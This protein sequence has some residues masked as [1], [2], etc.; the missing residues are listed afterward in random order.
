MRPG[1][2]LA[3]LA[4][5]ASLAAGCGGADEAP[6]PDA[7]WTSFGGDPANTRWSPLA[8]VDTRS[9]GRLGVA[10]THD[11]PAGGLWETFPLVDGR[12]MYLTSTGGDVLALDATTG[13]RRWTFQPQTDFLAAGGG[14]EVQPVSRGVALGDGRVYVLTYDE[15][16]IALDAETGAERWT[17]RVADTA[18]GYT[19]TSPP[20]FHDG[21]LYVGSAGSDA[22]ASRGF[23]AAHDARTGRRLWRTFTVPPGVGGGR[24]WMPPTVDPKTK[25]V[26]AGTGNPSPAIATGR[27]GCIEHASGIVALDAATGEVQWGE[28]EVCGDT[29]DFD[30]GQPPLLFDAREDGD[31]D[32][33]LRVAA[34]ANKS[35]L[36]TLYDA[37][38]G[39]TLFKPRRLVEQTDPRPRPTKDG[40]RV[41]PGALGGVPYGPAALNPTVRTLFQTT[42]ELCTTYRT[43]TAPPGPRIQLGGGSATVDAAR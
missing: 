25:T 6:P 3:C 26:Y 11:E 39:S 34:H 43:G 29:W 19:G 9:V 30:G 13:R 36:H 40:V 12:T 37:V 20:S 4:A 16:L 14:A 24:V 35:G 2:A 38:D 10:W 18:Q 27:D 8:D 42:V 15:R 22:R 1:R 31:P 17:V 7:G 23:V 5:A 21:V 41:C 28:S 33:P 32:T